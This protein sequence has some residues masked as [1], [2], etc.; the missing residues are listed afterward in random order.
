MCTF[1]SVLLSKDNSCFSV[2]IG[3]GP[4]TLEKLECS[5]QAIALNTLAWN[6][7]IGL[8]FYFVGF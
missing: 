6:N 8:W 1:L 4:V 7:G 3:L 5:K 2:G